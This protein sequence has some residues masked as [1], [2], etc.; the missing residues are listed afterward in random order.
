MA[1]RNPSLI[2]VKDDCAVVLSSQGHE[3]TIDKA[4]I[5]LVSGI[6]WQSTVT[7]GIVYFVRRYRVKGGKVAIEAMHR[8]ILN[9]PAHLVVDHIDGNGSN[10]RRSN[11]R[12]CTRAENQANLRPSSRASTGIVGAY[13]HPS[14]QYYSRICIDGKRIPLGY[15]NTAEEAGEAYR[16]RR[17]IGSEFYSREASS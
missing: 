14:G 10:N 2:I 9:P 1:R 15:F 6:A 13:R 8:R 7:S 4:D 16:A 5:P 3:C 12:I 11:L 17:N